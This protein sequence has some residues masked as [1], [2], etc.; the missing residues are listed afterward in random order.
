[1]DTVPEISPLE[2]KARLEAR[3]APDLLDVREDWEHALVTLPGARLIPIDELTGRLGE[4]DPGREVVVYCHHG[5]RSAAAVA[6][7]RR[8]Q[9]PAVNLAGGIDA[10]ALEVEPGLP[11]Y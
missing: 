10:W 11:R 1:M 4:L 2:L 5:L 9:I 7:L 3:P 8:Q 6:W